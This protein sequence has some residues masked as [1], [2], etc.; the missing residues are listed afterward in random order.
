MAAARMPRSRFD[1]TAAGSIAIVS[2]ENDPPMSGRRS[3]EYLAGEK[4]FERDADPAARFLGVSG[5][6]PA[7]RP[8]RDVALEPRPPHHPRGRRGARLRHPHLGGGRRSTAP[9][10]QRRRPGR[11]PHDPQPRRCRPADRRAPGRASAVAVH[12]RRLYRPRGGRGAEPSWAQ[13]HAARGAGPVLARVAGEPSPAS[14][15]PSTALTA[16]HVRTGVAV[17]AHRRDGGGAS[18]A[19]APAGGEVVPA[20]LV[21]VGIGIEPGGGCRWPRRARPNGANGVEVDEYCRTSLAD[22]YAVGD[23]AAHR[24]PASPAE[25]GSGSDRSQ[26]AHDQATVAAKAIIGQ[27]RAL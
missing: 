22:V 23:C 4:P 3:A 8:Q 9:A 10:C 26:N 14:T 6:S 11:R 16:S 24:E 21:I 18:R 15:R 7:A 20:E 27:R 19:S 5:R 25:R 17:E 2:R 1:S 12:R 13:G